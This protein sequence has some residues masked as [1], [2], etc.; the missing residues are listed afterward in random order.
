LAEQRVERR[1]AA[2]LAADVAGYSRLMG[3][4]E[5]GTH[6]ALKS[7]RAGLIDPMI[8]QHRGRIVKTT[9]DGALVEFASA[10]DAVR[11]AVAVQE[12]MAERNATVA[13]G[14]RIE[15]RIG[16]NVGDVISDGGDIYGDG[17]NVAARLE[18]LAEPGGVLVSGT[19]YDQVKGKLP[20]AFEDLGAKEVK[21]IAAPV[22][23]YKVA[24][25]GAAPGASEAGA[26]PPLSILVLPFATMGGDGKEDFW[27]DVLTE[28]ITTYLSRI[29]QSF[30][31]ARSTAFT[32]KGKPIDVKRVGKELGV[33]YVLEGSVQPSGSRVRVNAQ[34]IDADTGAHLWAE[35]FDAAR[36]DL[37][38]MQ[39][40]I[41]TRVARALQVRLSAVEAARLARAKPENPDAELLAMRAESLFLAY[42]ISLRAETRQYMQLCEEALQRDAR[43]LRALAILALTLAI[44]IYGGNEDRTHAA[45]AAELSERALA[46]DPNHYL[47]RHARGALLLMQHA[48]EE[49]IVEEERVLEL[50]PG[51]IGSYVLLSSCYSVVGRPEEGLRQIE[52]ALRLSPR[53]PLLWGLYGGEGLL[54]FMLGHHDQAIE[55]LRRSITLNPGVFVSYPNLVAALALTDRLDEARDWLARYLQNGPLKT[56][57]AWKAQEGS[58]NPV[59]LAFRARLYEGLRKAGMA[60]E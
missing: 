28:E 44:R 17:V 19:A 14:R 11:C 59:Y 27:G 23:V 2:I 18:A 22:R 20:F 4:D 33:R 50:N 30:V 29:P 46:I 16:V 49:A 7:H 52:K 57:A 48:H 26:P 42:G 3:E 5:E 31:I 12:G 10:V 15:F 36:G 25:A 41:V 38:D 39:D 34:L 47:A 56:I 60:E 58:A 6:A 37:L 53:D 51:Y 45:R 9:G 13:A 55:L 8:A 1:L 40:E 32:F 24:L 21:N 35:R 43:N 54:H